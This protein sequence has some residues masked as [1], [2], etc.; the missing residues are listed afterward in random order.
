MAAMDSLTNATISKSIGLGLQKSPE[1]N[2]PC[3]PG[4][5]TVLLRSFHPIAWVVVPWTGLMLHL[6]HYS[7]PIQQIGMAGYSGITEKL[8]AWF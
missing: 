1:R 7:F 5:I 8:F 2:Y 3:Y 6:A 4:E